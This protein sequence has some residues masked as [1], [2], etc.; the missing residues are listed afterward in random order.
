MN[1]KKLIGYIIDTNQF[2]TKKIENLS[3]ANR[4][5]ERLL[6]TYGDSIV[7]F[8]YLTSDCRFSTFAKSGITLSDFFRDN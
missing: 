2:T 1:Y 5:M 6:K 8:I 3:D 4:L 7:D